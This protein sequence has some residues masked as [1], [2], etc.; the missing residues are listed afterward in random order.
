MTQKPKVLFLNAT[1]HDLTEAQKRTIPALMDA[2]FGKGNVEYEVVDFKEDNPEL[3]KKLTNMK[4][5]DDRSELEER[6]LAYLNS[7]VVKWDAIVLH[8]PIG[9]PA[10]TTEMGLA[11]GFA[12]S[13]GQYFVNPVVSF[14]E[15]KVEE[16]KLEDGTVRKVSKF[17][18]KGFQVLFSTLKVPAVKDTRKLL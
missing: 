9:S 13:Q 2:L 16:E 14:T 7:K 3:Y 10:F 1:A 8:L 5:E 11:L 18:F 17:E 6:F 4:F 15:R 12:L